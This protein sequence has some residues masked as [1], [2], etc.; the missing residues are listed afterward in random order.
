MGND[1]NAVAV[2]ILVA[3]SVSVFLLIGAPGL[4]DFPTSPL[5]NLGLPTVS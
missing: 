3:K 4:I 1:R 2:G 5:I